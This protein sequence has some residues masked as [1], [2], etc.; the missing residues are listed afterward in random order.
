LSKIS[1]TEFKNPNA[2]FP[3]PK[4]T[5]LGKK[6]R[7]L[8][9]IF[10]KGMKENQNKTLKHPFSSTEFKNP[11]ALFPKPK[12]TSLGKKGVPFFLFF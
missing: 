7:S 4:K 11:N 2:L 12:K 3:K 6:G 10:L 1:S 9:L 5:S 8:F